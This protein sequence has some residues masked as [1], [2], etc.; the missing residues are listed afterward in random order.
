MKQIL[1]FGDSNTY[2]FNIDNT[3]LE[4]LRIP[5]H[6]RWTSQLQQNLGSECNI[7]V[8]GL[9]GRTIAFDDPTCPCRRGLDWLIPCLTTHQPLDLVLFMLGTND[10]K[11]LFNASA[12][13]IA[14]SLN[15]LLRTYRGFYT[16]QGERVPEALVIAPPPIG[17]NIASS[18]LADQFD[19]SSVQK[20]RRLPAE[21]EKIAFSNK[22]RFF[23]AAT[24][25]Q[26]DPIECVHFNSNGHEKMAQALTEIVQDILQTK[27]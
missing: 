17:E 8:E 9:C 12:Q 10:V 23:D 14:S 2:G 4:D 5:Y 27:K 15:L 25:T 11:P 26:Y 6:E 19:D 7:V 20:S 18:I 21:Y 24:V 16:G 13:N 1:C 22:A 3:G